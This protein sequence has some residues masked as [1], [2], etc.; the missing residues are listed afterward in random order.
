MTH[1]SLNWNSRRVTAGWQKS[2][3]A[4]FWALGF[5]EADFD[6]PQVGIGVP[7]LDGNIGPTP[8]LCAP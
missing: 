3:T 7:L 5:T 2:I 8:P 6:K 4:F 1:T